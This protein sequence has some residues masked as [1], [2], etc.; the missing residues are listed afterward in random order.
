[1]IS[2]NE[3]V[4]AEAGGADGENL[5]LQF[6]IGRCL[7]HIQFVLSAIQMNPVTFLQSCPPHQRTLNI[8]S[9]AYMLL[10]SNTNVCLYY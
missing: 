1:M 10:Q 4:A 8:D 6:L 3:D 2:T 9:L 5:H 7:W